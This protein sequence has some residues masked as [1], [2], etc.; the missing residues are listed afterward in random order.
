MSLSIN[1]NIEALGAQR[2]L[3]NTENMLS[4]SME[5]LS[6]GLRINSAA[7]DVAGYAINQRM[8]GQV[9][10]VN[11]ATQNSQDAVSMVQTAQGALNDVQQMLQ[12]VRELAVQY[13]NGTNTESDK[14]AIEGEVETARRRDQARRRNDQVQR[15]RPAGGS[16]RNQVPGRR[17][18]KRNDLCQN[19]EAGRS[20]QRHQTSKEDRIRSTRRSTKSPRP[21]PNSARCRTACSTRR[22]TWRST[23]RTSPRPRARW[24]TPTWRR[25]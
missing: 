2:N 1:T 4:T 14:E 10:G 19:R 13:A 8:Q 9:N 15:R 23:E 17:Q 18:R 16:Q 20:G 25:K 24:W 12:R 6:S 21:Q 5:R 3:Q 11:Q 22:A 7:D